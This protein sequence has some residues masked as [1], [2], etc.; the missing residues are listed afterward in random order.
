MVDSTIVHSSNSACI[1]A[2]LCKITVDYRNI[3][4]KTIFTD[5]A[6]KTAQIVN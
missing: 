4:D 2:V 5:A 1:F 3:F 6:E